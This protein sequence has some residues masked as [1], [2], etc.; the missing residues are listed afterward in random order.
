ML[1]YGAVSV[2]TFKSVLFITPGIFRGYSPLSLTAALA[3]AVTGRR[4]AP[5]EQCL[6]APP[7]PS[8]HIDMHMHAATPAGR[9][10]SHCPPWR[11]CCN[12]CYV[13]IESLLQLHCLLVADGTYTSDPCGCITH[14]ARNCNAIYAC[15]GMTAL[16]AS[17][18]LLAPHACTY[19][20][21]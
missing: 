3:G 2:F 19:V 16:A 18:V 15:P 6:F 20:D 21:I 13:Y 11:A 8:R 10:S 4:V 1:S 5:C 9:V 12:F 14:V 7:R 17:T